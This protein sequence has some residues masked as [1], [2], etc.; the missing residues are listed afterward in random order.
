MN[1]LARDFGTLHEFELVIGDVG[2][3]QNVTTNNYESLTELHI[4]MSL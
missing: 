2:H 3:L 1:I 4:P